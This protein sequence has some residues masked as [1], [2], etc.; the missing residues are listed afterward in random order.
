MER[1]RVLKQP[2]WPDEVF[3]KDYPLMPLDSLENYIKT[4]KHLPEIPTKETI[5]KEGIDV[6]AMNALLLKKIEELTLYILQQQKE[7]ERLNKE[8]KQLRL[9]MRKLS[10]QK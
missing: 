8:L 4:H 3:E 5:Q 7:I 9:E 2:F 6:G 10:S 1:C